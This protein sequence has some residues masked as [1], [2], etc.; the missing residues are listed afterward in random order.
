MRLLK[1][2]SRAPLRRKPFEAQNANN[3][4][5]CAL[6]RTPSCASQVYQQP[7]SCLFWRSDVAFVSPSDVRFIF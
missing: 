3:E 4:T 6:E 2:V 7:Q 5:T 1:R